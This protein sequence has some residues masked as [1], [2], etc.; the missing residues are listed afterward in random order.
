MERHHRRRFSQKLGEPSLKLIFIVT[1]TSF[2][3]DRDLILH[4][5]LGGLNELA[6]EG[7]S[8]NQGRASPLFLNRA[9]GATHVDIHAIKAEAKRE[10]R[11]LLQLLRMTGKKLRHDRPLG[12]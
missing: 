5:P 2:N 10:R 12:R 4:S 6:R 9:V 11:R 3:R 8:F 7:G 1:Q